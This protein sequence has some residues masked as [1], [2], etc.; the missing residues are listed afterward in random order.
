MYKQFKYYAAQ[1]LWHK[2]VD[3]SN[4]SPA[5]HVGDGGVMAKAVGSL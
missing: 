5:A 3:W 1:T 4:T 2:F